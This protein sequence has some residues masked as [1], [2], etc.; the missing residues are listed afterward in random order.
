[1]DELAYK[2][3][4]LSASGFCCTQVM[5][6]MALDDEG[7][8]NED[9]VR[10]LN[11]F[12]RGIGGTQRTCGVLTGGISVLGLYAGKG[13]AMEYSNEKF[14]KMV[15]D[16]IQWFENHFDSIECAELIGVTEFENGDQ[17]YQIKCGNI[18]TESYEKIIS[19]IE[20]Y[21]FEYGN[22]E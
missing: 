11:G 9:L 1:M 18:L 19:I 14:Q 20:D 10:A 7:E 15:D 22:R 21:G 6:K 3:F 16:Y 17:S 4:N 13:N 2:V 5:I 8:N 12:C